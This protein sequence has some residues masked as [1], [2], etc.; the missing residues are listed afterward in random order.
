MSKIFPVAWVIAQANVGP[1]VQWWTP[2]ANAGV[3]GAVLMFFMWQFAKKEDQRNDV[4]RKQVDAINDLTT[5]MMTAVL[6]LNTLDDR[7]KALAQTV[8][9]RTSKHEGQ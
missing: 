6:A 8:K 7:V 3:T 2:L 5:G 4:A 1:D 9:D